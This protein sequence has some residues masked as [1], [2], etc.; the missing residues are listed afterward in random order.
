MKE[1]A[2][3]GRKRKDRMV[4]KGQD[5][6]NTPTAEEERREA[7]AS[8]KKGARESRANSRSWRRN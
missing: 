1:A 2:A 8:G 3:Q 4:G 5:S 6:K 7:S